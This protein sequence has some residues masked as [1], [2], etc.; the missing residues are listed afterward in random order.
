M[1]TFTDDFIRT[2]YPHHLPASAEL[3]QESALAGIN[4]AVLMIVGMCEADP[5]AT[6]AVPA[7]RL[8]S[9]MRS[10]RGRAACARGDSSLLIRRPIL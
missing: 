6:G 5:T 3:T 10:V 4:A 2:A 1:A 8:A 7:K 9:R